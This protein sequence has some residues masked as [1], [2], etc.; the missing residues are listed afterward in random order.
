MSSILDPSFK[1]VSAAGTDIRKT[2]AR[3]RR[4]IKEKQ[5]ADKARTAA[6]QPGA[7]NT[8]TKIARAS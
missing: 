4:E 8:V 5:A 1:Y 7:R 3:A 6:P 2:F